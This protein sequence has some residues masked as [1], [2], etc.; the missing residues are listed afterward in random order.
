MDKSSIQQYLNFV[1][2]EVV[3][4][5]AKN[6]ECKYFHFVQP[7][8][9]NLFSS[10]FLVQSCYD[11]SKSSSANVPLRPTEG[12]STIMINPRSIEEY[13]EMDT[14]PIGIKYSK[15]RVP[16]AND[17]EVSMEY[18]SS[19][20]LILA[21]LCEFIGATPEV[22]EKSVKELERELEFWQPL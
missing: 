22:F 12:A 8:V 3:H 18:P 11:F 20:G 9:N 4:S 13:E 1:E 21:C 15:Y 16:P 6:K 17:K 7:F 19:Y 10:S 2:K 14:I 5:D